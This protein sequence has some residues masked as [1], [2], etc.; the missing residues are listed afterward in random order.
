MPIAIHAVDDAPVAPVLNITLDEDG[1]GILTANGGASDV[2]SPTL[3]YAVKP[4]AGPAHGTIAFDPFANTFY[5][6]PEADFNGS[7]SAI[8][9]VS[10]GT[11]TVEQVVNFTVNAVNDAPVAA[12]LNLALDED[13]MIALPVNGGAT[14]VDG[15]TLT[16]TVKNGSEPAHG[17]MVYDPQYDMYVY[18]P[19]N[20]YNGS[21]S[22][23]MLVSD[24]TTRPSSRW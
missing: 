10:D 21:D 20:D 14:D 19:N 8:M 2:D 24:G 7:D 6:S 18:T 17:M 15:D 22:V 13:G 11:T 23:V 1:F 4:G 3:T 16:Y 9:L 5:F 12:E